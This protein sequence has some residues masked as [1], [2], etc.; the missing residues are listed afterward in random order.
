MVVFS[1]RR[2]DERSQGLQSLGLPENAMPDALFTLS[3]FA[4]EI[5]PEPVEQVEILERHG[6]RHIEL[7]S[8]YR[9]NVLDLSDAQVRD[10]KSLLDAR[11]FR[12]S[13][14]GSPIGKVKITD[15]WPPHRERFRRAI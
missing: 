9:T 4:D 11:G 7:R 6:V 14:I 15:P 5:G 1:A 3:A 8:I 10:F 12:L 13:A 2:A